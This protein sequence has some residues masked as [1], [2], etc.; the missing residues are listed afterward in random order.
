MTTGTDR[1]EAIF[2]DARELQADAL[3][4]LAEGGSATPPRRLGARRSGQATRSSWHR[5]VRNRSGRP[6]PGRVSGP[7]HPWTRESGAPTC[8]GAHYVRQAELHGQYFYN[9]LCDPL[10]DTDRPIRR[11]SSYIDDAE[12]LAG[13]DAP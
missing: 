7:W 10:E 6:R 4:M 11:T 1:I 8:A 3:E 5:P 2:Q 13:G 12:R 9:G